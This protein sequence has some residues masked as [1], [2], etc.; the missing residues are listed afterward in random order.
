MENNEQYIALLQTVIN[1]LALVIEDLYSAETNVDRDNA[2]Q[3]YR[4]VSNM[5][6]VKT[7]EEV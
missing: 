5:L 1:A 2:Y 6:M 7:T 3:E 4:K